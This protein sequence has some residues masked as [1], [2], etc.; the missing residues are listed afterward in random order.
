MARGRHK[1][2]REEGIVGGQLCPK[3]PEGNRR[4]VPAGGAAA[5]KGVCCKCLRKYF[6]ALVGRQRRSRKGKRG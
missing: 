5:R 1:K 4:V 6:P 2:P 3:C